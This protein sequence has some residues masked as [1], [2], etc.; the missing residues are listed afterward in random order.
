MY[1]KI[2]KSV[3]VE[4]I[5]WSLI[6]TAIGA[7]VIGLNLALNGMQFAAKDIVWILFGGAALC[8]GLWNIVYLILGL[9]IK[10]MKEAIQVN[11][12]N[13]EEIEHDLASGYSDD[14]I[15]IGKKYIVYNDSNKCYIHLTRDIIWAYQNDTVLK[16]KL[17]GIVKFAET[18]HTQVILTFRNQ[19][20]YGINVE[21]DLK[22]KKVLIYLRTHH[23]QVLMGYSEQMLQIYQT[24]FNRMI[25]ASDEQARSKYKET[26]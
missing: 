24:D 21:S 5:G 25:W 22:A 8:F 14:N 4:K 12:W 11:S 9:D 10:P 26:R 13:K 23:S 16:H 3:V 7:F 2:R 20:M 17:Y 19:E 6:P 1:K 18:K 15:M